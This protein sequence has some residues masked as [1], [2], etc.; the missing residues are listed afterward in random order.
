MAALAACNNESME[1]DNGRWATAQPVEINLRTDN[2]F[3]TTRSNPLDD[4]ATGFSEGDKILV[5]VKSVIP[6][7]YEDESVYQ[8]SGGKWIPA[9]GEHH[10]LWKEDR[11]SF[12]PYYPAEVAAAAIA[13]DGNL[14]YF[15]SK[16]ATDQ[17]TKE[18]MAA[19]DLMM[20]GS[21]E[22]TYNKGTVVNIPM[23]HLTTKATVKIAA[24]N[25]EFAA[26]SKVT[27]VK[28]VTS[29]S[30]PAL[31]PQSI[32]YL[33]YTENDGAAGSQYTVLLPR[34]LSTSYQDLHVWLKVNG[35]AMTAN[36]SDYVNMQFNKHYIFN[37]T[38]GKERLE[39]D[40]VTV[41]DWT[42]T[43]DLPNHEAQKGSILSTGTDGWV[44]VDLDN[45][46]DVNEAKAAV[47]LIDP[48]MIAKIRV[49][50]DQSKLFDQNANTIFNGKNVQ[51]LDLR[52]VTGLTSIRVAQFNS[53]VAGGDNLPQLTDVFLPATVTSIGNSAFSGCTSLAYVSGKGVTEL[54]LSAFSTCTSLATLDMP[55]ITTLKSACLY[56]CPLT[57]LEFSKP[58]VKW[59][60]AVLDRN[61]AAN[62]KLHLSAEQRQ[63]THDS[64]VAAYV[65]D[66]TTPLFTERG[67]NKQFCSE[68]EG[69][70]LVWKEIKEYTSGE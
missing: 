40:E 2:S 49:K 36:I 47:N 33:P 20:P 26:G 65:T 55:N 51:R 27:D 29:T 63:L 15:S 52:E 68:R 70:P 44:I 22:H 35:K 64:S 45:A 48:S 25:T 62:I 66:G 60:E 59:A 7:G 58:I 34:A 54:G 46:D 43:I 28:F 24:F 38:V 39:V 14:S 12:H 9:T 6:G 67:L 5:R 50:G 30:N 16:V 53:G 41:A 1:P 13:A 3:V 21:D 8:L 4:A 61:Q 23:V 18:K 42:N 31:T 32:T 11:L 37:L 17:S 19:T 56:G 69:M 57:E 10:L